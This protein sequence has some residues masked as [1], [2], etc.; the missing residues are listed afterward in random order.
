MHATHGNEVIAD[1]ADD[2]CR[3]TSSA[4]AARV[5]TQDNRRPRQREIVL[6]PEAALIIVSSEQWVMLCRGGAERVKQ[7]ASLNISHTY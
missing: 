7:S 2:F 5:N 6:A 1:F 3:A 4:A